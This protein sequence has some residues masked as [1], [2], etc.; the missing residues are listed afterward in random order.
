MLQALALVLLLLPVQA[1]AQRATP[2][3][4]PAPTPAC[5]QT[6]FESY[7]K[8][9]NRAGIE[10]ILERCTHLDPNQKFL[11]A[12]ADPLGN[13]YHGLLHVAVEAKWWDFLETLW[14][15]PVIK[16]D[17]RD[18]AGRSLVHYA[19][20][21]ANDKLLEVLARDPRFDFNE[22]LPRSNQRSIHAA[23][24]AAANSEALVRALLAHPKLELGVKNRNEMPVTFLALQKNVLETVRWM[25]L[26]DPRADFK[27][28]YNGRTILTWAAE[29][30]PNPEFQRLH[31]VSNVSIND[32]DENGHT[33]L[34]YAVYSNESLARMMVETLGADVN[35]KGVFERV[36]PEN[37]P[38][39]FPFF[40]GRAELRINDH[41]ALLARTL[42][43]KRFKE[44][45]LIRSRKDFDFEKNQVGL[46]AL[47]TAVRMGSSL[48]ADAAKITEELA[49]TPG[50]RLG[51]KLVNGGESLI[52]VIFSPPSGT[53][54]LWAYW[55]TLLERIPGLDM[56][57]PLKNGLR[58]LHRYL[59]MFSGDDGLTRAPGLLRYILNRRETD[60]NVHHEK[61]SPWLRAT[62]NRS[63]QTADMI[64]ADPR[65]KADQIGD[66]NQTGRDGDT[67][68]M[69]SINE[70][71][72][73][74]FDSLLRRPDIDVN[75]R[76]G[77]NSLAPIS[78]AFAR[79]VAG[80]QEA[81]PWDLMF[82]SI[83]IDKRFDRTQLPSIASERC[84]LVAYAVKRGRIELFKEIL[85]MGKGLV[86]AVCPKQ[87]DIY[88]QW[89]VLQHAVNEGHREVVQLVYPAHKDLMKTAS[90]GTAFALAFVK[91]DAWAIEYF[92]NQGY[93]DEINTEMNL[94]RSRLTTL[95]FA[96]L[97]RNKA[98]L[99]TL[100]KLPT[101]KFDVGASYEYRDGYSHS[102]NSSVGLAAHFG[103]VEGLQLLFADKRLTAQMLFE[104]AYNLLEK[105]AF[106]HTDP[107]FEKVFDLHFQ[108]PLFDPSLK[109]GDGT[110]MYRA[111][112]KEVPDT[113]F[114]KLITHKKINVNQDEAFYRAITNG[115]KARA[116][117][118]FRHPGFD[119]NV[120]GLGERLVNEKLR[121]WYNLWASHP[122]VAPG[123]LGDY[124]IDRLAKVGWLPELLKALDT[125]KGDWS[126]S[127]PWSPWEKLHEESPIKARDFLLA[128]LTKKTAPPAAQLSGLLKSLIAGKAEDIALELLTKIKGWDIVNFDSA[129]AKGVEATL[130]SYANRAGASKVFEWAL[131]QK[132]IKIED[133]NETLFARTLSYAGNIRH[134]EL[135][136]KH[137]SKDVTERARKLAATSAYYAA[138]T[139]KIDPLP[140]IAKILEPVK[141]WSDLSYRML[142]PTL[143]RGYD[144]LARL[145][146]SRDQKTTYDYLSIDRLPL[147]HWLIVKGRMQLFG[148][149]MATSYSV[150][151]NRAPDGS[152]A[153]I[154]ASKNG[155]IDVVKLLLT[156]KGIS[157]TAQDSNRM[158]ALDWAATNGHQE[159]LA[160]LKAHKSF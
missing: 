117:K 78:A 133:E 5:S 124:F 120:S 102:F 155:L 109:F 127:S 82:E 89:N 59:A 130:A 40:I 93:F 80:D 36:Y 6:N 103:W 113:V 134:M 157:L 122:K 63:R 142:E 149:L 136:L 8:A 56:N 58:P 95:G 46:K 144:D 27:A 138:D 23:I 26:K 115:L 45:Y 4:P 98:L 153:L 92:L 62:L 148:A 84:S 145:L 76:S 9:K 107:R 123:A 106:A 146:M 129:Y 16:V 2:T 47:F 118:I 64:K 53:A 44:Y 94:G 88:T 160:L 3:P 1:F 48:G 43:E 99:S 57:A 140:L 33:P 60:V 19:V 111:I 131:Q 81:T 34:Y 87:G 85:A 83:L 150:N 73:A 108:H 21:R 50:I 22:P 112:Q 17:V 79:M 126:K 77:R 91:N 15:N 156:V 30:L 67:L 37:K 105:P 121:D 90:S 68:L 13:R 110:I 116:E 38:S 20:A 128:L 61:T 51:D 75:K 42:G 65:F 49:N 139:N 31:A 86:G 143:Q 52:D 24:A 97:A 137:R 151:N 10:F 14:K 74:L 154:H 159:I 7:V 25:I 55:T 70:G 152:T 100:L 28:T 12:A 35:A 132:D 39:L 54:E 32:A 66:I 114:N 71:N 29:N 69:V 41:G 96:V 158:T 101:L 18:D 11:L 72:F 141:D 125:Y 119:P 135:V 104:S 147:L